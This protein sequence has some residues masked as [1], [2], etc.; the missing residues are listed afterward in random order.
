MTRGK[1]KGGLGLCRY[2]RGMKNGVMFY[3]SGWV[4]C[5]H[6]SYHDI[7]YVKVNVLELL[8][9]SS[10]RGWEEEGEA[11]SVVISKVLIRGLPCL[12]NHRSGDHC[13]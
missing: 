7:I 2:M 13:S 3:N 6:T 11:N 1:V 5:R 4:M 10:L 12:V 8:F 9:L